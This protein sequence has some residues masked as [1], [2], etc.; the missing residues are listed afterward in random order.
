VPLQLRYA[1]LR[2]QNIPAGSFTR[3]THRV[4]CSGNTQA[5]HSKS[6]GRAVRT[7]IQEAGP[8]DYWPLL[9]AITPSE[10]A[11]PHG[12]IRRECLNFLIPRR[13]R[14]LKDI[15]KSRLR[16]CNHGRVHMPGAWHPGADSC[17]T[18]RNR[19]SAPASAG[20]SSAAQICA[21]TASRVRAENGRRMRMDIV[22]AQH[23][24]LLNSS[25]GLN[26][27]PRLSPAMVLVQSAAGDQQQRESRA[28]LLKVGVGSG[29][30][31]TRARDYFGCA[32]ASSSLRAPARMPAMP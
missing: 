3:G 7:S 2:R 15:L 11:S 30:I 24:S 28:S 21:G 5:S 6:F 8:N 18:S 17:L 4:A 14:H 32:A 12:T 25:K 10:F 29:V 23:N 13:Q 1:R 22:I 9:R 19:T 20:L 31:V 26:G 16:H 27:S